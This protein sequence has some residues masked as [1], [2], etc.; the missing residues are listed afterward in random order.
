MK[1]QLLFVF[2]SFL[3]VAGSL[4]AQSVPLKADIPFNFVV[5]NS[6]YHAGAYTIKPLGINGYP[7]QL[8]SADLNDSV[9]ITPCT[10]ASET[11]AQH[12]S[13]LVFQL[14]NGRYFL[15][16][17]WTQGYD[18]GRQLS[19]RRSEMYEANLASAQQV[20]IPARVARI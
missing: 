6:T 16:Q 7:V 4:H 15:W 8:Q 17:I 13:K 19:I 9:L 18:A 3:V 2:A 10:C 1:K 5:G 14:V 12:E 20:V 11:A